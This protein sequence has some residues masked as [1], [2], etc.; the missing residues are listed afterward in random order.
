MVQGVRARAVG[1][2][3]ENGF[4]SKCHGRKEAFGGFPMKQ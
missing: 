1:P 3:N 2:S 4:Y